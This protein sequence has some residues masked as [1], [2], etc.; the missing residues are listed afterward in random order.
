MAT[1]NAYDVVIVG[2]GH[3]GAFIAHRLG[4]QKIRV[5]VI[6]GGSTTHRNREDYM[7]NF[8]LSTFKSPESPYPPNA[9]ALDPARTNTPR[10]TIQALVFGWNDPNKSYLTYSA[11]SQP[12]AST[13]ERVAGGTGLHWMGTSLRMDVNDFKTYSVYGHGIDWPIGYAD[14]NA[15][16]K[17]VV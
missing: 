12:F 4:L 11:Q 5:L 17:S 3:A 2:S 14:L 7:E 16:R 13:Y 10:P 6:E 15:D 8:Y 9:N 1:Q